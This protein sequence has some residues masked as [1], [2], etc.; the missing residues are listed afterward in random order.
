[1]EPSIVE[2]KVKQTI[3]KN[4]FPDKIVRLPFKPVY[5]SCKSSGLGLRQV[6]DRLRE[7]DIIGEIQ[8][9]FILFRSPNKQVKSEDV[10]KKSPPENFQNPQS[11]PDMAN[12]GNFAQD[13]L[14]KFSPDQ[15]DQFRQMAENLSDE[16]K[17]RI[18][19]MAGKLGK[20]NS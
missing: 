2:V 16:E 9:D 14:S 19:E 17:A 10:S 15:I 20:P 12:L 5:D 3:K 18:L 7:E 6:L 4:G 1:M 8:G 13:Y 11:I